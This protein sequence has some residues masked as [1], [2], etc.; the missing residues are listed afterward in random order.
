MEKEL[1]GF[2]Y[3]INPHLSDGDIKET[4]DGR[5]T[6]NWPTFQAI[7]ACHQGAQSFSPILEAYEIERGVFVIE[8]DSEEDRL[9]RYESL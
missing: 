2:L 1:R 8:A 5:L 7:A 3:E 6:C 4:G 9:K